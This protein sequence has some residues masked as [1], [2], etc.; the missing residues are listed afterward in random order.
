MQQAM[1]RLFTAYNQCVNRVAQ[2]DDRM[3]QFRTNLRRD[4]LELTL[5]V[6]RTEQDVQYQLQDIARIKKTLFEDIQERV[7]SLE[8]RLRQV[9]DH[10]VHVNQ[11][12]D[13]NTNSQCASIAA[14]IAEQEDIRRLVTDLANR[15][16]Q[17]QE[18]GSA[19]QLE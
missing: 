18:T 15:L 11:T 2:T 4:A 16:D 5:N 19:T 8:E 6:K 12:I 9:M 1:Q 10:E 17:S 3:E 13:R 7:K 14:I